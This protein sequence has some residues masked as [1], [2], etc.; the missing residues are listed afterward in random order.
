MSVRR[1][2]DWSPFLGALT[3]G[4]LGTRRWGKGVTSVL[5]AVVV[6]VYFAVWLVARWW[7][8]LP[9]AVRWLLGLAALLALVLWLD[10]RRGGTGA[11]A[12]RGHATRGRGGLR[13]PTEQE[14][15]TCLYRLYSTG[16][17]LLYVGIAYDFDRRMD[18]HAREPEEAHWWWRVDMDRTTVQDF[19]SRPLAK[20]AETAAILGEDG[21]P[22]PLF[23]RQE[24]TAP[25]RRR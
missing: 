14:R 18:E 5:W 10:A 16:G 25:A 1:R 15:P 12:L 11:Q 4:F 9:L 7:L 20:A 8:G 6:A 23:N 2:W 24:N 3:G 22:R 21:E 19:P 17:Q 13:R